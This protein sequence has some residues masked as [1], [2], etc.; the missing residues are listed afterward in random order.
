M[1]KGYAQV[2]RHLYESH[3]WWRSREELIL[4]TLRRLAPPGGFGRILDV[5]CG[6]GLL[7]PKLGAFGTAEG[8]ENDERL[9]T[10]DGRARGQIHVGEFGTDF[11][12]GKRYGLILMLDVLEHFDDDH[13]CLA[14]AVELLEPGGLVVA[15]VPALPA[16]WTSH[17]GFNEH[18]RRYGR[19]Q[20]RALAEDAGLA[21]RELRFL[22]I[23]M[24]LPK[25]LVRVREALFPGP[26][27]LPGVPPPA[28]NRALLSVCRL[29]EATWGRAP[30]P[31]GSSLLLV[32]ARATP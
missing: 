30:W 20:L 3:W 2:Y 16:L 26:R 7:L 22:F 4:R 24:T 32:G 12:P 17:D 10:G 13:G 14:R 6:D 9:L 19:G 28:I 23:W 1:E 21:L 29:E 25:L 11:E 15:T 8:I 5:G 27:P 18:R 31:F